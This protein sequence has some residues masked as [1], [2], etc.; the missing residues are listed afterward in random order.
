MIVAPK[1]KKERRVP[2]APKLRKILKRHRVMSGQLVRIGGW[3]NRQNTQRSLT[4]L[5]EL[6]EVPRMTWHPLRHT[7]GSALAEQGQDYR[8]IGFLMGHAPGSTV[9]LRYLHTD[10]ERLRSA[11]QLLE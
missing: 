10:V 8:T 11:V 2:I 7:F 3:K 5:C 9:T 6:A 4:R 1:T